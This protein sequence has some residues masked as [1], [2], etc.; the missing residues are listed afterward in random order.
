MRLILVKVLHRIDTVS[1]DRIGLKSRDRLARPTSGNDCDAEREL[2][3]ILRQSGVSFEATT[4]VTD[5]CCI[6]HD[7]LLKLNWGLA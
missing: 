4:D 6:L 1:Y 3:Q 7:F 2:V 5:R